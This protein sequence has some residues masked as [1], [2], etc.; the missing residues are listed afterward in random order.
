M[1]HV[2]MLSVTI[3]L[4]SEGEEVHHWASMGLVKNVPFGSTKI[5][6]FLTYYIPSNDPISSLSTNKLPG[7]REC[8]DKT[9]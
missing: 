4:L 6:P 5:F 3:E 7:K 2:V 8:I 1:L 9:S